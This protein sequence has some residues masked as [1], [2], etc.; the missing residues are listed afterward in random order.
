MANPQES[1]APDWDLRNKCV[2]DDNLMKMSRNHF[3]TAEDT[4]WALE[5]LRLAQDEFERSLAEQA[6]GAFPAG[7]HSLASA[8]RAYR[9]ALLD[10]H[11]PPV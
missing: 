9:M 4:A 10:P 1:V 7:S 2:E 5:R 11:L 8:S 6:K 3:P